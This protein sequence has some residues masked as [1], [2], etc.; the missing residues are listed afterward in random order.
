[1]DRILLNDT[2]VLLNLLAS[3]RL[4]EIVDI[5]PWRF[6]IADQVKREALY[7]VD[8]EDGGKIE[9]SVDLL[10]SDGVLEVWELQTTEEHDSFLS[11]VRVMDDGEAACFALAEARSAAVAIDDRR[12]ISQASK[13]NPDFEIVRTPDLIKLWA[14]TGIPVEEVRTAL[15][16]IEIRSR[17]VPPKDHPHAEWWTKTR[18]V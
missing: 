18:E 4:V 14:D 12:A 1:M 17:Y 9:V 2:S 10:V 16:L 8:D 3:G 7:L 15:Q 5:A 6:A 13:L 11:Y